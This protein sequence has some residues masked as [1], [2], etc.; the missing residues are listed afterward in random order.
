MLRSAYDT[1]CFIRA[2]IYNPVRQS[3]WAI[4]FF[5]GNTIFNIR[6]G[7]PRPV[8]ILPMVVT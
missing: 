4:S 5:H 6:A 2:F 1:H 7:R 8:L 3:I